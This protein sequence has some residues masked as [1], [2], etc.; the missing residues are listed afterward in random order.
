MNKLLLTLI[1]FFAVAAVSCSNDDEPKMPN[2]AIPLN[3]MN[4]DSHTTIGGSDVYIN[5]S[6]NFTT[7]NCGIADLGKR[8]GFDK[9]PNLSQIAQEVAVTPGHFYQITLARSI[10]TVAGARALPINTNFY[11]VYVDSWLYDSDND[12]AGAKISYAECYPE[13]KQLPKWDEIINIKLKTKNGELP[14][15]A[16]YSFPKGCCIDDNIEIYE[17]YHSGLKERLEIELKD[18]NIKFSNSAWTSDGRVDV[19]LLVRYDNTYSR[20]VMNVESSL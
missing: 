10:R 8:G 19:I 4:G 5:A 11:N 9:N 6:N 14:E 13:V 16:V 2:N 20:V 17:S 12:I 15:T 7:N 1:T 3:M 18:N